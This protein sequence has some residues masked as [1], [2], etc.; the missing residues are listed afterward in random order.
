VLALG[1]INS[2]NRSQHDANVARIYAAQPPHQGWNSVARQIINTR[3]DEITDT[4]RTLALL[5]MSPADAH[6]TV[7]ESTC[8]RSELL[9]LIRVEVGVDRFAAAEPV[10]ADAWADRTPASVILTKSAE[11][12]PE[13]FVAV[14]V[15]RRAKSGAETRRREVS[16]SALTAGAPSN[17]KFERRVF[18]NLR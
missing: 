17:P 14:V 16:T 18:R 3:N 7:F 9:S 8:D 6:I 11:K 13:P 10:P 2:L 12:T 5:N 15:G 1:A 4:A